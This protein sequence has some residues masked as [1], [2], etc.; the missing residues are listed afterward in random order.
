MDRSE[1]F[2]AL[3]NIF[4]PKHR[5]N[6]N[7]LRNENGKLVHYTSAEIA[8]RIIQD[9]KVWMR[10]TTTMNDYSEVEHGYH[11]LS[12]A[13]QSDVGRHFV[14]E[15]QRIAPSAFQ[16]AADGPRLHL[17]RVASFVTCLSIHDSLRENEFG[18]LSMW[19]AYCGSSGVALV[20]NNTPFVTDT[21]ALGAYSASVE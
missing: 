21:D 2:D 6:Y 8:M 14:T 20:L 18:R 16:E 10:R 7:R 9:E 17:V 5:A 12:S 19:R 3:S 4:T 11:G 15:L 13:L 1:Q